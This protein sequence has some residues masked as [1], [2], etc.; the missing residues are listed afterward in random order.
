MYVVQVGGGRTRSFNQPNLFPEISF[1]YARRGHVLGSVRRREK[2]AILRGPP[3]AHLGSSLTLHLEGED[4][5]GPQGENQSLSNA[6]EVE[7]GFD[8]GPKDA[9]C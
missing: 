4:A 3:G 6:R 7:E 2:E 5:E 9:T 8:E 1:P